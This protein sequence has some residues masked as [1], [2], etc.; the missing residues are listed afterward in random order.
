MWTNLL[1]ILWR[2]TGRKLVELGGSWRFNQRL[3]LKLL[4]ISN[5]RWMNLCRLGKR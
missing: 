5:G 1:S 2:G 3:G 4:L